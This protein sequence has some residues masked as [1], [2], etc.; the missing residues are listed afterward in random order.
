MSVEDRL[1]RLGLQ[2]PAAPPPAGS[3]RRRMTVAT[4]FT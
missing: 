3:Y 4:R 2:L 1:A